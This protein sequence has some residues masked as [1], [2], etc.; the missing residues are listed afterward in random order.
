MRIIELEGT[1]RQMG[2]QMGAEH[3][4]EILGLYAVRVENAIRQALLYGRRRVD[5]AGLLAI[6]ER[7]LPF[8]REHDYGAWEELVGIAEG[9]GMGL[10]RVWMMNALTD[11]RDLAAYGEPD[12]VRPVEE[13][14]SAILVGE[15]RSADGPLV[16]QTWDLATDNRPFIRLVVRRPT[17]EPWT[18]S[19]TLVGCLS[20]VGINDRGVAVGTTNVR[21]TDNRLGVGYLDVIHRALHQAIGPDAV[22]VVRRAPRAGAHFYHVAE[23]YRDPVALECSAH[24]VEEAEV[25]GTYVHTNHMLH[26][27][28]RSLE[29]T[30]T[31]MRSSWAR[32]ARLEQLVEAE[33]TISVD[34]LARFLADR[35]GGELA[36][37]RRDFAGISTNGAVVM[38]PRARRIHAV[39]GPVADGQWISYELP[40]PRSAPR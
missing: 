22:E 2:L 1:R 8:V 20:L 19:M 15:G 34:A 35:E 36:V 5:E 17:G 24:V 21:A 3:R 40:D 30:G 29:V 16:A 33:P 37:D 31:P 7:C 27:R 26:P 4:S 23:P 28:T 32:Q 11:V 25:R 6:A 12:W 14:C 10:P 13:G 38:E 39:W 18:A 9:S